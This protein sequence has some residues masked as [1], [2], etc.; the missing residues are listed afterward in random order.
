[1]W[2]MWLEEVRKIPNSSIYEE[3][4]S[5]PIRNLRRRD[6][7]APNKGTRWDGSIIGGPMVLMDEPGRKRKPRYTIWEIR[8]GKCEEEN[9]TWWE[10]VEAEENEEKRRQETKRQEKEE[11]K[12][13]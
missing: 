11:R 12:Q 13:K 8:E 9:S 7:G 10:E 2:K 6:D 3:P 4:A 5:E 1:M